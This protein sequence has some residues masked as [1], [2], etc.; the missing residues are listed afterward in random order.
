M[1]DKDKAQ[2]LR[3][4]SRSVA[5]KSLEGRGGFP[6]APRK[7]MSNAKKASKGLLY[8]IAPYPSANPLQMFRWAQAEWSS[9][10]RWQSLAAPVI[11][12][13]ALLTWEKEQATQEAR[14]YD[15]DK[16]ETKQYAARLYGAFGGKKR[17]RKLLGII[18]LP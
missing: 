1:A 12:L 6:V 16:V 10:G 5:E 3:E 7:A 11:I 14:W 4:K 2:N 9:L 15:I 13:V 17:K 18:P 8:P